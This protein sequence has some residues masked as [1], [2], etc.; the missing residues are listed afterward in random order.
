MDWSQVDQLAHAASQS[1]RNLHR[2][3]PAERMAHEVDLVGI[4]RQRG[5]D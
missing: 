4:C 5:L 1:R 2:N 3:G